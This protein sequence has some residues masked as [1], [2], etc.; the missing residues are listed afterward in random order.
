MG[1][2]RVLARSGYISDNRN[3]KQQGIMV[4]WI[5]GIIWG[6]FVMAGMLVTLLLIAEQIDKW[7]KKRNRL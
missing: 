6:G 4:Y 5:V 1:L 3:F 2:H 7:I